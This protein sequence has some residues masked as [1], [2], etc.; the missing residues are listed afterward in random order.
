MIRIHKEGFRVI[1][2]ISL[3]VIGLAMLAATLLPL[4]LIIPV[5]IFLLIFLLLIIRF[6][7]VPSR[8]LL[9][10]S[11]LV[12]APADGKIVAIE[13][14][15]ENEYFKTERQV[16]SIFMSIY[17]VH[18]NYYPIA[19][20]IKYYKYHPG[21]YLVARHPKSSELNERT[22]VVIGNSQIDLL[23]RQIAGYVARRIICYASQGK[24]VKQSEELGFIRFGS[25]VDLFLPL[26]AHLDVKIGDKTLGGKTSIAHFE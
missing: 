26:D 9:S 5:L 13:R 7:R 18:I 19:G 24:K 12:I 17:N 8:L 6:F 16:V 22:T 23:V 21:N 14:V 10:D 1:A 4:I 20:E 11:N 15:Q 25:R 2:L 3:I